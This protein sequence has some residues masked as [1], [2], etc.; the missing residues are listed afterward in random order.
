MGV[1]ERRTVLLSHPTP[2]T[3]KGETPMTIKNRKADAKP[4]AELTEKERMG[5]VVQTAGRVALLEIAP[6]T[7]KWVRLEAAKAS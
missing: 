2:K 7:A 4:V 6:H 5:R 3:P 1:V